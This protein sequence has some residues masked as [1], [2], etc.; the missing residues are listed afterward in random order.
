MFLYKILV[1]ECQNWIYL[2]GIDTRKFLRLYRKE[3]K[4]VSWKSLGYGLEN[5]LI[6]LK[7]ASQ[8]IIHHG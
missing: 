6:F 5:L 7:S 8:I 2:K 4:P 1:R 3:R